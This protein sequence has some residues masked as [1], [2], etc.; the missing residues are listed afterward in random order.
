MAWVRID[1]VLTDER[2]GP[3]RIPVEFHA[4]FGGTPL[5]FPLGRVNPRAAPAHGY[6]LE[7][8][9]RPQELDHVNNAV[10]ADWLD[11]A[12]DAAGTDGADGRSALIRP[13]SVPRLVRLEYAA[14]APPAAC[15]GGIAWP[16]DKG[17]S[18]RLATTDEPPTELLRARLEHVTE[19]A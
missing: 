18:Y 4:L 9:V 19:N 8:V 14:A 10:Y 7:L 16:A 17:W 1:W 15:L 12:V 13:R 11:E 3:T 2:G 6:R 5:G